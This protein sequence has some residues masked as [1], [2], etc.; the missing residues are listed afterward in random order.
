MRLILL[1]L[2]LVIWGMS[3]NAGPV[4]GTFD[5]MDGET[6][7][8]DSWRGRPV[9]IVNTASR[10]GFTSQ[11]DGLQALYDRHR[12]A[13]LIVLA[14]PSNDFRQELASEAEVKQFCEVNFDLDMPMTTITHVR[15]R[16]AHPFFKAVQ[17]ETGFVPDWNFNKILIAP[18]GEVAQTWGA[19]TEPE[20]LEIAAQIEALLD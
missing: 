7:S 17:A 10:C 16:D 11:Y 4:A 6:I 20:S 15:G 1:P 9:L 3:A 12:G 13:G 2:L 5:S 19:T 14:I 8:L 18:D